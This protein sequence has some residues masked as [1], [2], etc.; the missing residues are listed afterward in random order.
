MPDWDNICSVNQFNILQIKRLMSRFILSD[1]QEICHKD[2]PLL[3]DFMYVKQL[4]EILSFSGDLEGYNLNLANILARY[5][6]NGQ[7]LS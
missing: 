3:S 7:S 4:F 1:I 5:F 2:C 6:F